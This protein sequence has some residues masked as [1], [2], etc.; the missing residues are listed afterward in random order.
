MYSICIH[1][2]IYIYHR[3]GR[4]G[5]GAQRA[6]QQAGP[7]ASPHGLAVLLVASDDVH[8]IVIHVCMYIYIYI[9]IY[10]IV[11]IYMIIT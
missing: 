8:Y 4:R 6:R 11:Y 3:D 10:I 2:Y 1:I 7:H 9:Y 5:C